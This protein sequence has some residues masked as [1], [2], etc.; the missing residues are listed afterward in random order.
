[1]NIFKELYY[2][3]LCE[4]DKKRMVCKDDL[5]KEASLYDSIKEKLPTSDEHLLDDFL[6][7]SAENME[8]D[9]IE[10][11]GNGIIT[12]ILIGMEVTNFKHKKEE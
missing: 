5:Q 9:I 12:G 11:Y 4:F 7:I 8:E 6:D 2:G 10:T 1:M 3:N